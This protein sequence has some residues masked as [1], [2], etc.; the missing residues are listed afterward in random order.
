MKTKEFLQPN[1]TARAKMAAVKGK[2]RIILI[3][4]CLSVVSITQ[5][6]WVSSRYQ[7]TKWPSQGSYLSTTRR[8]FGRSYVGVWTK[9]RR[10]IRFR[11]VI[12]PPIIEQLPNGSLFYSRLNPLHVNV[13]YIFYF[14]CCSSRNGG[15]DEATRWR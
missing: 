15:V 5:T 9:T 3:W 6:Y 7:Q 10:R 2:L 13:L 11:Y 1:P 12:D 4:L 8:N 14:S